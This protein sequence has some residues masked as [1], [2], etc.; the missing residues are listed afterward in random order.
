ML[1]VRSYHY[2]QRFLLSHEKL[3]GESCKTQIP[4]SLNVLTGLATKDDKL[5]V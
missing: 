4:F 2:Q 3:R 5:N 1:T